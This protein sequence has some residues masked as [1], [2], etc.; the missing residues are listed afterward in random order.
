MSDW[1]ARVDCFWAKPSADALRVEGLSTIAGRNRK[2]KR[3]RQLGPWANGFYGR[4][5]GLVYFLGP[6][7][8]A[9]KT[10]IRR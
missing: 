7:K 3:L 6:G 10:S 9:R 5:D 8:S 2:G 1:P 4:A